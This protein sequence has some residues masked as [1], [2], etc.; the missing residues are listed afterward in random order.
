MGARFLDFA[1]FRFC[2]DSSSQSHVRASRADARYFILPDATAAQ[3]LP[4]PP[5]PTHRRRP[6]LLVL[7][8]PHA[9]IVR[10]LPQGPPAAQRAVGHRALASG[11]RFRGSRGAGAGSA[12]FEAAALGTAITAAAFLPEQALG[13]AAGGALP[14]QGAPVQPPRVQRLGGAAARPVP[15]AAHVFST[16]ARICSHRRPTVAYLSDGFHPPREFAPHYRARISP[17]AS[18]MDNSARDGY[19]FSRRAKPRPRP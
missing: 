1:V 15:L 13:A 4:A 16:I 19:N 5:H 10:C 7:Q 2:S 9:H 8:Q 14:A 17:R 12:L 18:A 3:S 6:P 11:A